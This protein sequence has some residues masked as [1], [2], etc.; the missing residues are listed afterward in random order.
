MAKYIIETNGATS[1]SIDGN[2]GVTIEVCGRRIWVQTPLSLTPY[3]EPDME[4]LTDEAHGIGFSEGYE[5]GIRQGRK[6][7][8]E[9]I[10]GIVSMV[11]DD[12]ESTFG[13]YHIPYILNVHQPDW[14]IEKFEIYKKH[15]LDVDV[16][17]AIEKYGYDGVTEVLRKMIESEKE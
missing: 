14:L 13:D 11:P 7:V 6:E 8:Y 16:S 17:T 4:L 5:Q 1:D 10:K 3:T 12:L 2:L 15:R 9:A